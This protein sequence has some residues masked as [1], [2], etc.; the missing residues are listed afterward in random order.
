MEEMNYKTH[1]I[2]PKYE[3]GN[4]QDIIVRMKSHSARYD[5]YNKRKTIKNKNI[6]ISPSLTDR[7]RKLLGKATKKYKDHPAINFLYADINGDLKVCLNEPIKNSFAFRFNQ[8]DD[9]DNLFM[10]L[11]NETEDNT[12]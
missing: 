3:G 11:S 12:Q 10:D 1:K 9:I 6:R 4:K 5:I 8:L 7:R 2:G